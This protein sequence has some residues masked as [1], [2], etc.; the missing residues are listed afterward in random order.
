MRPFEPPPEYIEFFD[1]VQ[2]NRAIGYN[3]M[4]P[5]AV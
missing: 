5:T 4:L 2:R 1:Q 3:I